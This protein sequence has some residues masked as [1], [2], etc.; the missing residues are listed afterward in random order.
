MLFYMAQISKKALSALERKTSDFDNEK[1][2][3][4]K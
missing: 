3:R 2:R 1:H 4:E